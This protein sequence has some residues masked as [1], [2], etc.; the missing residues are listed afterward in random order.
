[1]KKFWP[2][3]MAALLIFT[4]GCGGKDAGKQVDLTA[5]YEAGA[6]ACGWPEDYMS[7]V[8]GELL[9]GYYPGLSEIETTQLLAKVPAMSSDVNELVFLQCKNE[10]DAK[11]AAAI[12]QDRA[13][14]QAAGNAWYSESMEAW[15]N[16]AVLRQG[17]YVALIAS[18]GFQDDWEARFQE[19]FA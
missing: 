11:S 4:S 8:E 18:M 7:D 9:E 3:T 16:A 12:L 2:L 6:E 14:D 1:M 13:D 10:D 5:L 17:T 19:A 15:E